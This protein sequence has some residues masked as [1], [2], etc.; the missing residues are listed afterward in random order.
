MNRTLMEKARCMLSG[1]GI[2]QELW[3][4]A[5]GTACYL[6]NRSP[7]SALGERLHKRYGL[8]RNLL[9]HI[10]RYLAAMH[11]FMFQRKIGV[12]WIRRLKN[13]SLLDIN[14]VS[15]VISFG[16]QKLRR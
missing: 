10:L 6:V 11:M 9:S 16:T 7:S 14:M 12:S 2:G 4:E 1:A 13:V 8:V 15:K 5:V 3:A